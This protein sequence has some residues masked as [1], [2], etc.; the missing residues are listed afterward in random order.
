MLP[1]LAAPKWPKWGQFYETK[2]KAGEPPDLPEAEELLSLNQQWVSASSVDEREGIW[3]R[4]LEIHAAQV[5]SIG[6]VGSVPQ[7]VVVNNQLRNV[8][9]KGIYN[10][11][12]GAHF[13]IYRLDTFWFDTDKG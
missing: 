2:G 3:R 11:Q 6:I 13:G 5:F 8:P 9:K 1:S 4:M 10:W 12:P 7:P